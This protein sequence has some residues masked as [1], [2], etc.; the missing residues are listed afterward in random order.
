MLSEALVF[1]AGGLR[2][3]R[4]V[5]VAMVDECLRGLPKMKSE[6]RNDDSL[7]QD[8]VSCIVQHNKVPARNAACRDL[9][10]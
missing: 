2:K 6:V 4:I 10:G 8:D 3:L 7:K 5:P 9:Y 1:Q